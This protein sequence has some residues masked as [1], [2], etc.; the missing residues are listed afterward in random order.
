VQFLLSNWVR[1]DKDALSYRRGAW[2][3]LYGIPLHAWNEDFFKLCVFD[4]GRFLRTDCCSTEKDRLDFARVLIATPD[5]GIIKRF[6]TVLV[7]GCQVEVKIVEEWGYAMGEDS[8]LF[9]EESGSDAAQSDCG[10]GHVDQEVSRDVD[11]LFNNI[12]EG[13]E[14]EV[15]A[16]VQGLREEESLDKQIEGEPDEEM[17]QRP[18]STKPIFNSV[19]SS[20]NVRPS[21]Q[22]VPRDIVFR[23]ERPS[24]VVEA[25]GH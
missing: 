6:E 17:E 21:S 7:D 23:L 3:R 11:A 10:E 16:D 12:K 14:D 20:S 1:W 5:L 22:R 4:C 18:V 15:C 25:Q 13:L 9:D 19:E 24:A 8:C 2:V